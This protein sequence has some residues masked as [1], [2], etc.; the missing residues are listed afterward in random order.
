MTSILKTVP[1]YKIAQ[2]CQLPSTPTNIIHGNT[3]SDAVQQAVENKH[4]TGWD[5]FM[6]GRA[7][8]SWSTA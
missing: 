1:C 8:K 6:K 7:A 4:K 2:W 5:N 3:I